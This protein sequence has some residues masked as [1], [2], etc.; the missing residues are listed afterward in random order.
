M[1]YRAQTLMSVQR[2]RTNATSVLIVQTM[3]EAMIVHVKMA[4]EEMGEPVLT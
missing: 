4:S 1:E 2:K 3:M